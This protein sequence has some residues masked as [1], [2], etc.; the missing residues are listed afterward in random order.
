MEEIEKLKTLCADQYFDYVE[1][2]FVQV[3][4]FY[5][6]QGKCEQYIKTT[7]ELKRGVL[8]R[9]ALTDEIVRHRNQGGRRYHVTGIH[10]F[11][12]DE[13]DLVHFAE[14]SPSYLHTH[15]QVELIT[16]PNS[17]ELFQ[18]HNS[19]FVLMGCD[20]TRKSKRTEIPVRR[21]TLKNRE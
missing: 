14:Q 17:P 9:E 2:K 19:V 4:F 3:F 20:H 21:M 8:T 11:T 7:A 1:N 13:K 10:S 18:H 16:F 15:K 5:I 6:F 12:F